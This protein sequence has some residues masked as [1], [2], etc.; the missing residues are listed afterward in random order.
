MHDRLVCDCGCLF[1]V[2]IL[3]L[4][5]RGIVKVPLFMGLIAIDT[6]KGSVLRAHSCVYGRWVAGPG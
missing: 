2:L 1:R 3:F 4:L 6:F 5:L